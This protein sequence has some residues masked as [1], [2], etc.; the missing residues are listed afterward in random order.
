M[1]TLAADTSKTLGMKRPG[2]PQHETERLAALHCTGLLDTPPSESFDRITRLA[3]GMLDVP[4]ALVSLVDASRQWFKSHHGTDL[5][6]T[7]REV[8]FCAHAIH[9]R[10]LLNVSDATRDDRFAGNPLVLGAPHIRAYLGA[11]LYSM[12]GHAIGTLCAIDVRSREFDER[13]VGMLGDLA[14][15]LEDSIRAQELAVANES[16]RTSAAEQERLFHDT[17]DQAAVG[18]VHTN[19][20]GNLVRVNQR[21]CRMLGYTKAELLTRSFIDLT[22]A[23]DLAGSLTGFTEM[24]A[25]AR[26]RYE[27]EK[28]C[29]RKDGTLFWAHMS[30]ALKRKRSGEPDC[31]ISVIEDISARKDAERELMATRDSLQAEV[32]R[33]T[34]ELKLNN[35]ELRN[36]IKRALESESSVR[37]IEHR[38]RSIA[39]SVPA[40]IGYWNRELVCEFANEGFRP[41]F[42]L[43]PKQIVGISLLELH[44]DMMF[45][46]LEP[47]VRMAFLGKPQRFERKLALPD[48]SEAII[49]QRYMPDVHDGTTVRG[50]FVLATDV[51]EARGARLA[52]E[53]AN[54]RLTKETVTDF[55]TGISNRRVFSER[56]EEASRRFQQ[57][58]EAYGLI[59]MDLDNF[60]MIND[61]HG[62]DVGDEV[63]RVV[64]QLLRGQLRSH[65]DI[66]ARLGGEE[67]A[68]L[69]FGEVDEEILGL[70][71]ERLRLLM[72]AEAVDT[73]TGRLNF[74]CSFGLA[75][76]DAAD[77]GW[78]SIYS[79]ADV[80]LYEAKAAGK[81]RVKFGRSQ[82]AGATGRF[83]SLRAV[84]RS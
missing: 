35:L 1:S 44:G 59:L 72:S 75:I 54:A 27:I 10:C 50:F 17:F 36:N 25:G 48:G 15:V 60:K 4:V 14:R 55:L 84:S 3:A 46:T 69:C 18:I 66:A 78:K 20:D 11:P 8:S 34:Q 32:A 38:M 26:D 63:L 76:S 68:I 6:E 29:V 13:Q 5:A 45:E 23:D 22:Y 74:T 83:R 53:A 2:T 51:T 7:P 77:T 33:Q 47:H 30:G 73:P 79:R 70:I 43:E 71:A 56:S 40:M 62:H 16:M 19:L 9:D 82:G 28:R 67:F 42:G 57:Q 80:A 61:A 58:G 12:E 64:G 24:I 21:S 52:L 39:D 81:D 31:I 37:Q 49:E 65:R 41:Y